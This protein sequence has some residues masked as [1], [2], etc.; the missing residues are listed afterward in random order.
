[1]SHFDWPITNQIIELWTLHQLK[2]YTPKIEIGV[3]PFSL[4][5][6]IQEF[7]L[8]KIY[9]IKCGAI[10]NSLGTWGTWCNH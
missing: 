6:E 8:G 4:P 10:G 3:F 7:N 9:D 2:V 5:S 1:M